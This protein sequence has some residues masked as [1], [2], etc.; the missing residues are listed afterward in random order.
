[1]LIQAPTG[2]GKTVGVLYPSLRD[3]L[4]RGQR[5]I[6]V[7]PK[8]SQHAVAEDAIERLNLK[9]A[10]L[11]SLTI[12]AKSKICFK[13]EPLC[14]P[15]YCEYAKDHYT[16]CAE[17]AVADQIA[18]KKKLGKKVFQELGRKFEVCPFEIQLDAAKEADAVICDYNYVFAPRSSFG[19]LSAS[20]LDQEGKPNLVMDEAHNLP[21][22]AMD[23][24][25]PDLST[26]TLEKLRDQLKE[27]PLRFRT[28]ALELLNGSIDV[29]LKCAPIAG[30][31]TVK[32][33]GRAH[34]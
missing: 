30:G 16:K 26:F 21:A 31:G 10:K 33:I 34:V 14:N 24:Y 9:G 8:N 3:A 27:L 20:G 4:S 7:T 12:T 2:L 15:S 6:Y 32:K 22:R 25:S 5:V 1:M 28:E 19:N 23:Y 17:H 13:N 11:K 18:R 29:I